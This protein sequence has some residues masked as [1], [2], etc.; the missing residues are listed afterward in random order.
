M[1]RERMA[2]K[3]NPPVNE[4]SRI[5][6]D[7][8]KDK[9]FTKKPGSPRANLKPGSIPTN[10]CFVQQK[11]PMKP[12]KDRKPVE[13]QQKISHVFTEAADGC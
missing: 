13:K 1:A 4:H 12:P 10:F 7:Y 11:E 5:S 3:V 6:G 9:C 2:N 8:F